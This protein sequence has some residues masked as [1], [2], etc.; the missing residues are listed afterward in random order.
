MRK[1]V[2][3]YVK[4][5]DS[6]CKEIQNFLE[7]QDLILNIRDLN[8]KPLVFD[9]LRTMIRH[10]NL[11]HFLDKNS[12]VYSKNNLSDEGFPPR[13]EVIKLLAEDNDLLKK[14]IIVAGRLMVVGPNLIKVKEMLQIKENGSGEEEAGEAVNIKKRE[15]VKKVEPIAT[16]NNSS[17]KKEEVE[18]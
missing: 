5:G 12:K 1:I 15:T 6:G 10:L 8:L 2:D 18:K 11:E 3:L 9:E 14:P 4:K 7:Q 16:E 17:K 13:N